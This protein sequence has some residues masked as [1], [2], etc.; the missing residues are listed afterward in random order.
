MF[1]SLCVSVRLSV[2]ADEEE[3]VD[4]ETCT[5]IAYFGQGFERVDGGETS[6]SILRKCR[7]WVAHVAFPTAG[8]ICFYEELRRAYRPARSWRYAVV[9][10]LI[11][12]SAPGLILQVSTENDKHAYNCYTDTQYMHNY[13]H[14][15]AHMYTHACVYIYIYI[16]THTYIH[17]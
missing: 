9:S 15:Y 13:T 2:P 4:E 6:G 17:I 7:Y 12:G 5:A 14:I 16:Y 1:L 11:Y 3:G 10:R 8:V